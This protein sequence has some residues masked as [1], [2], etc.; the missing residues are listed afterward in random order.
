[1]MRIP[2]SSPWAPAAGSRVMASMPVRAF[3]YSPSS[4]MSLKA[5]W[6]VAGSW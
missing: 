3:R 6:T 2:V 1:M 5:P 4:H